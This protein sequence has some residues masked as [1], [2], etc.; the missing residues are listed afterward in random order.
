MKDKLTSAENELRIS[1]EEKNKAVVRLTRSQSITNVL[2]HLCSIHEKLLL[3][4]SSEAGPAALLERAQ[5]V[6]EISTALAAI[7][8]DP[9]SQ[10]ADRR[11]L[12]ALK[13]EFIRC[14]SQFRTELEQSWRKAVTWTAADTHT[15]GDRQMMKG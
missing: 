9:D 10:I 8:Y 14:K 5:T 13:S 11:I 6:G 15:P 12:K 1:E 7:A 4:E 3:L 2:Q